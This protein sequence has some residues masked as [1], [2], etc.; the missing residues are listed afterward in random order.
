M[1]VADPLLREEER[2]TPSLLSVLRWLLLRGVL[3]Q[4]VA[5][6]S[7]KISPVLSITPAANHSWSDKRNGGGAFDKPGRRIL[8][9]MFYGVHVPTNEDW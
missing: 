5:Q 7:G 2:T 9:I 1:T 8:A 4:V 6:V 3:S